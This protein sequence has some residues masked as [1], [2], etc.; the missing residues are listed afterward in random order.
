M[1]NFIDEEFEEGSTFYAQFPTS[2]GP[3][4]LLDM[5]VAPPGKRDQ[6]LAAWTEH[7]KLMRKHPGLVSVQMHQ[8]TGSSNV[9]VNIAVWE[10]AQALLEG[11]TSAEFDK[12][13]EL[14]PDGTI[15]RRL[16]TERVAIP[17]VCLA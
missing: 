7:A 13:N 1:G 6:V 11:V 3:T 16:L 10:S 15:C 8:G 17:G 5:L 2:S 4:V 9:L 14:Y 12:I